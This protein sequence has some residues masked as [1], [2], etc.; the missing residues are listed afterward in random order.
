MLTNE[1][2]FITL[3]NTLEERFGNSIINDLE[4]RS[5]VLDMYK[6]M[7]SVSMIPDMNM[8]ILE[9]MIKELQEYFLTD[10]TGGFMISE[11]DQG[12]V[13]WYKD[14]KSTLEN[15]YT[16]RF[17]EYLKK[18]KNWNKNIIR[19]VDSNTDDIMDY[20][21]DPLLKSSWYRKGLILGDVQCGNTNTYTM[22]T[23]K[24][25]DS[26]YKV[27]IVLSGLTNSLR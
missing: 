17:K 19:T 26:G 2:F 27:I 16:D 4:F 23:N 12:H 9:Q 13:K 6:R 7:M 14:R 22:I 18:E 24:A 25:I 11:I 20:L 5:V 10:Q 21:G 15:Q 1:T 8:E 3:K